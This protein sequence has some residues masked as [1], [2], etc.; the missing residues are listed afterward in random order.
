VSD[1]GVI[2]VPL[3]VLFDGTSRRDGDIDP[4]EFFD[5]LRSTGEYPTSAAPAPGEFLHAFKRAQ[6][7]G[8]EAALCLTLSARY[9][10]THSSAVNGMALAG[11]ELPGFPVRVVDT[12]GIAMAHGFAVMAAAEAAT[13]GA[14]LEQAA[15]AAEH[16]ANQS[17]LVGML[18]GTRYLAKGGRVP[19]ALH[20]AATAL[21]IKPIIAS[22]EGRIGP[23]GRA[24]TLEKGIEKLVQFVS[25][26]SPSGEFFRVAAMHAGAA[27]A[28]DRLA[29]RVTEVLS[30][31]EILV[32]EFTPAMAVHTG[33]GFIGLAWQSPGSAED[34]SRTRR[35][36]QDVAALTAALGPVPAP[37][38]PTPFVVLSGLPG[39]GKSHLARTII[40]RYPLAVVESDAM[41]RALVSRPTYSQKESTRLF[42]AIHSLCEDLLRRGTPVLMDATNLKEVHRR[43]LY[44]I[45]KRTN[46]RLLL[47]EARAS[48]GVIRTR[49]AARRAL[50]DPRELSEATISVYE[51]MR[52]EAEPIG[53]PHLVIDT[54]EGNIEADVS[55]IVA[56][57]DDLR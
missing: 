13:C 54:S 14:S 17:H 40:P 31:A 8:A 46:A 49:L 25:D 51:M 7:T 36:R 26:K 38:R 37:V 50:D 44:E 3:A 39:T 34:V 4:V 23:A 56:Q 18:D 45:A 42:A 53:C 11:R 19:S 15:E 1:H 9:S 32:T 30:P 5:R 48:D 28:A 20:F 12:G 27:A 6:E 43:P 21:G 55:R 57:L 22:M 47:V 2:V 16:T 33:P 35:R 41:R 29:A 10:G 24:R 52:A